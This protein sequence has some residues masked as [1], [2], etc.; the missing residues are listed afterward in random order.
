MLLLDL[1][2]DLPLPQLFL[3]TL[4]CG[5]IVVAIAL[6]V[7]RS[8]LRAL[9][10]DGAQ[11]L[12][13]RESLIGG[14]TGMFAIMVAFSAAGIWID[15]IQA[16]EAVQREAN[17]LENIVAL[18]SYLPDSLRKEVRDEIL[19]VGRRTVENDWPAMQRRMG[20]ND[21]LFD[22]AEISPAL[23]LIDRLSSGAGG[24]AAGPA[25]DMMVG[26][27]IELRSARVQREMIARHGVSPAQ[28]M[29]LVTIPIA[30]LTLI[31]LAYNHD[32]RWQLT[33]A[34][35][36]TIAVCAAL[37]VVL[38]H[39]RPFIGHFGIRPIP[40]EIAMQRI[41]RGTGGRASSPQPVQTHA[42]STEADDRRPAAR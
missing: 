39:D 21:P 27:L 1:L 32:F 15:D 42:P 14:L 37:F 40:I 16:R 12:A 23:T 10:V 9:G 28:W 3:A 5:A 31:I 11:V 33:A 7:V 13:V 36:Y 17:A 22:R 24:A 35:I 4:A 29:A 6:V 34:S 20:P 2:Q 26:Q 30:A 25:F 8:I 41:Q 19:H 38:A 18:S